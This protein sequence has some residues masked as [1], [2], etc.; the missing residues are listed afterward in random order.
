M[1]THPPNQA[2]NNDLARS[3]RQVERGVK[4]AEFGNIPT[5]KITAPPIMEHPKLI[6]AE[7]SGKEKRRQRREQERNANKKRKW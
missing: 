6:G 4:Q 2:R 3:S 7:K 5:M 1:E